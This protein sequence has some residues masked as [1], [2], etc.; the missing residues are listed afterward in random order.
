MEQNKVHMQRAE[1]FKEVM[2]N[3][4]IYTEEQFR[5]DKHKMER[6]VQHKF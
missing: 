1:S 5:I 3:T 4:A 2:Q 6:S